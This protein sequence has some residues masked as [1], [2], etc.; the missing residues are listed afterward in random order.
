MKL[1]LRLLLAVVFASSVAA[2]GSDDGNNTESSP[3]TNGD[4]NNTNGDMNNTNGDMNNTNGDMNNTNGETTAPVG[5]TDDSNCDTGVCDLNFNRCVECLADSQCIESG[6]A[7]CDLTTN[8]C[9]DCAECG[10]NEVCDSRTRQCVGCL[11][12]SN[13]D[14]GVCDRNVNECVEC[15]ND[16][17][18]TNASAQECNLE[19][20]TCVECVADDQCTAAG[21]ARCDLTTNTCESCTTDSQCA[22]V[23]GLNQCDGNG[24]C[25]ECN[26]PGEANAA[27]GGNICSDSLECTNLA[28]GSVSDCSVD[29]C[30]YDAQCTGDS[31]CIESRYE[32]SNG[33]KE[34]FCLAPRPTDKQCFQNGNTPYTPSSVDF[35]GV[36]YCGAHAIATCEAISKFRTPCSDDADCGGGGTCTDSFCSYACEINIDC[37]GSQT[38]FVPQ[39][40]NS[41][42]CR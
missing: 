32:D 38:C 24:V 25:V 40:Q 6:A 12:D 26:T 9:S 22:S 37:I 5:C 7:R 39:G 28:P 1:G 35:E 31:R 11:D 23:A 41:G 18:C 21:A 34:K 30:E 42:L 10:D 15:L 4:T 29:T 14:T 36:T 19:T 20:N 2:C 3:V 27:C 17:Q 33:V 8:T 13:C 16:T